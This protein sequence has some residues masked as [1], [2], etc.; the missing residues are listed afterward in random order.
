MAHLSLDSLRICGNLVV[1]GKFCVGGV[2]ILALLL[3]IQAS[4]SSTQC[5]GIST[6][7][8]L[9]NTLIALVTTE[10]NST[11]TILADLTNT[12]TTC[13]VQTQNNFNTTFSLLNEI[14]STLTTPTIVITFGAQFDATFTAIAALEN[15][16]TACCVQTQ[17]DF[18]ATWTI[19]NSITTG[20][21]DIRADIADLKG[22]VTACCAQTQQDFDNT[23]TILAAIENT[24]I[25]DFNSTWT[26]LAQIQAS[27]INTN[28]HC[29]PV[30]YIYGNCRITKHVNSML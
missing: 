19:L 9:L 5:Q 4:I 27:D 8:G 17:N 6:I 21:V 15:T 20:I 23:W 1:N 14:L 3:N 26:I 24:I 10:F 25:T 29:G 28:G 22:T 7:I 18:N 13:C 16:V 30:G 2:D 12:V 11:F